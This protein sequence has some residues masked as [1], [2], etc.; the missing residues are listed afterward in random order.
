M[1]ET[2]AAPRY[3]PDGHWW[4]DGARWLP[5]PQPPRTPFDRRIVAGL[6][7]GVVSLFAAVGI[8]TSMA[9]DREA[10]DDVNRIMCERHGGEYCR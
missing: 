1:D 9:S 5:A 4:W 2:A 6:V 8:A 10:E 7:I 3:S